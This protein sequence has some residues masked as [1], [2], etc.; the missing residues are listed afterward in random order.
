MI[1]CNYFIYLLDSSICKMSISNTEMHKSVS[2]LL[3]N[4]HIIISPENEWF[5]QCVDFF[6]SDNP[7]VIN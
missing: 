4:S 3:E 1:I 5:K 7:N 6:M 2:R